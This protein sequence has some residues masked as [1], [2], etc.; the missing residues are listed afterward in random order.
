[1]HRIRAADLL[2]REGACPFGT[3]NL[4]LPMAANLSGVIEFSAA[5]PDLNEN[6]RWRFAS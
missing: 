4:S 3:P 2:G 5:A 1:M 6:A